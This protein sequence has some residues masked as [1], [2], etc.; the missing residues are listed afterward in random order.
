MLETHEVL[1]VDSAINAKKN[2]VHRRK[3]MR[4]VEERAGF[5]ATEDVNESKPEI[6]FRYESQGDSAKYGRR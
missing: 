6:K 1:T 3:R 5:S 4:D 2:V